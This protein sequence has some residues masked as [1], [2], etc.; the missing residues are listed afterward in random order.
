ML[1]KH[2]SPGIPVILGGKP[3]AYHAQIVFEKNTK[4]LKIFSI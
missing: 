4:K 1:K 2:Y 3:K